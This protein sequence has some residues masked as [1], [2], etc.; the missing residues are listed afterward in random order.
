MEDMNWRNVF[1]D[2]PKDMTMGAFMGMV[3]SCRVMLLFAKTIEDRDRFIHII[4][5]TLKTLEKELEEI[6]NEKGTI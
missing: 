2:Y 1:K 3:E 4:E 6:K 5:K